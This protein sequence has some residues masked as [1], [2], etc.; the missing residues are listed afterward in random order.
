V[1]LAIIADDHEPCID[2]PLVLPSWCTLSRVL[3]KR[4][5]VHRRTWVRCIVVS[6]CV[7]AAVVY[8]VPGPGDTRSAK[9]V[10]VAYRLDHGAQRWRTT[11]PGFFAVEDVSDA[12]VVGRGFSCDSGP[13]QMVGYSAARGA[14]RW[15]TPANDSRPSSL[16]GDS[17][18]RGSN[19]SGIVISMTGTQA[20]TGKQRWSAPLPKGYD[21]VN[22]ISIGE[23]A[24]YVG[25]GC[26]PNVG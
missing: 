19:R 21:G 10:L 11:T 7:L 8:G 2:H 18:S 22:T 6:A 12:M 15:S 5:P 13:F 17:P 20:A 9:G 23:T 4:E 16:G 14:R 3:S 25:L 1:H 24:V 26:L